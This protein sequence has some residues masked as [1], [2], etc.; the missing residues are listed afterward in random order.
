LPRV[1]LSTTGDDKPESYQSGENRRAG[2]WNAALDKVSS[3]GFK[4]VSLERNTQPSAIET[5]STPRPRPVVPPTDTTH[6]KSTNKSGAELDSSQVAQAARP[7][8]ADQGNAGWR[9]IELG[10]SASLP[11][12]KLVI[13]KTPKH[14]RDPPHEVGRSHAIGVRSDGVNQIK[15]VEAKGDQDVTNM[16]EE[17][18]QQQL[19]QLYEQVR[20][21]QNTLEEKAGNAT[22]PP[23]SN[24]NSLT[25]DIDKRAETEG[26][27]FS[28][29]NRASRPQ[30][31]V[32]LA[33]STAPTTTTTLPVPRHIV[34]NQT[35]ASSVLRLA[36]SRYRSSTQELTRA[37]SELEHH[38]PSV[39]APIVALIQRRLVTIGQNAITENDHRTSWVLM[40]YKK[41]HIMDVV[42][43]DSENVVLFKRQYRQSALALARIGQTLESMA[44]PPAAHIAVMIRD[45]LDEMAREASLEND[46]RMLDLMGTIKK[47]KP[48]M[49]STKSTVS[50]ET[51]LPHVKQR[52]SLM[53][54]NMRAKEP[55]IQEKDDVRRTGQHIDRQLP[56]T[57][58]SDNSQVNTPNSARKEPL[59]NT[60]KS[61]LSVKPPPAPKEMPG[62]GDTTPSKPAPEHSEEVSGRSTTS[63][64]S[65]P[66][67]PDEVSEQSLLEELFPEASTSPPSRYAEKQDHYPKLGLPEPQGLVRREL[68]E[69]PK[70]LKEQVIE[71]FQNSGEK[72]TILQ[73]EHCSTE[74]TEVDFRRLIP[75]GKHIEAWNRDGE[76][77]KVIPGRDPLS[78]ERLPFY[79][80]LFRTPESAHA[81]QKNASRLHKLAALHQP[82]SIFSAIPAPRGF[83]EDGED[84]NAV[85]ASYLLK[86]TEHAI[87]LRTLMQPYNP[88]LRALIEQGGYN[89]I[90][91][92]VD[93]KNNRIYKVLMHI[94]GY[95]PSL[96]ELFQIFKRDAWNRGMTLSL[97]NESLSS[98][99][100]LRDVINLK[101]RMQPISTT[102]P[103]AYSHREVNNAS[104]STSANMKFDFDDPNISAFMRS[105]MDG[106]DGGDV[107]KEIN[108][109]V[110]N[111]VYNRW[112]IE[113]DDEDKARRFSIAWHRR[114][115]PNLVKG[116]KT[117]KDY[118]EVRMCNCEL[119]W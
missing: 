47:F 65:V 6:T 18:I 28:S 5:G 97:R 104:T 110:M 76:F 112:I 98:V 93:D 29:V 56:S 60:P 101:T 3:L 74:L 45:R 94:E 109:M 55:S 117:W 7:P 72:I 31:T 73:L 14:G 48:R 79:Y 46:F 23:Q 106:D 111:R 77:Y 40:H 114:V 103:R 19:Q 34:H 84:I 85:T 8:A 115:L 25:S 4:K 107:A 51:Q 63:S 87:S 22:P 118:E 38:L 36:Q 2:W 41:G 113:F 78:L 37:A 108:Q 69:R 42:L 70:T 89:P 24:A 61:S 105:G 68:V 20:R 90:V 92:N 83:L 95:E 12:R 43:K 53:K 50:P 99:H 32:L 30:S 81:Y 16:D 10:E 54:P 64:K 39:S 119:L 9:N 82:S 116:E 13:S 67:R 59:L 26:I 15:E 52:S 49:T 44:F 33:T 96:S 75:K 1:K 66:R 21:L 27:R 100:R 88:S 62:H 58:L 11:I 17:A 91:P 71:S 102:N 80:L 35:K 86:P 57:L